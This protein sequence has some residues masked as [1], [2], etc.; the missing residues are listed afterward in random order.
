MS[1]KSGDYQS[2]IQSFT[3]ALGLI[4]LNN[5]FTQA[6][7]IARAQ[8]YYEKGDF[9]NSR[10]DLKQ[11]LN[12]QGLSGESLASGLNLSA[13]LYLKESKASRAI[14]DFTLAIRV[15]H[16]NNSLKSIT[17]ANR[18]ITFLNSGQYQKAI[19][20]FNRAIELDPKSSFNYAARAVADLRTDRVE[21]AREDC[22]MAMTMRPD[23]QS[24]RLVNSVM[25]ELNFGK[26]DENTVTTRIN[27]DG[28]I[29]VQMKFSKN[30]KP[31]RFLLDTGATH[32]LIDK[33]LLKELS[34]ETRI[35]EI[36]RGMVHLADGSSSPVTRYAVENAFLY[37]IRLG[38]IQ[39]QTID[40]RS[41]QGLNLL[42][43]GSLKNLSILIDTSQ[44]LVQI[45]QKAAPSEKRPDKKIY[46]IKNVSTKI[47]LN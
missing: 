24:L 32:S 42:G 40:K 35:K 16:S 37:Q 9:K 44:K 12:S 39:V 45:R 10:K 14:Q 11:A 27:E 30:G 41:K 47:N 2:A 13:L 23:R 1:L 38:S 36:G 17:H 5:E 31:H 25:D 4:A 19:L 21:K 3:K 7:L 33:S 34:R 20:D 28:Q 8:A 26:L 6:A 15:P 18:G 22:Q 29:F 46:P 43:A